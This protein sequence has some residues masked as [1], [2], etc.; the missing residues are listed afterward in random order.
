[1]K[2]IRYF[3]VV[4]GILLGSLAGG[5]RVF[6]DFSD[7]DTVMTISPPKQKMILVPG[8]VYENTI[9]V[10][11]PSDSESDLSYYVSVGSFNL[12]KDENGNN[13]DYESSDVDTITSRNQIMDWITLGKKEGTVAPGE[14]D[15]I[16][17]TIRVPENA[18]AGGQYA[19]I[20]VQNGT[21]GEE[22]GGG[23]VN[24]VNEVRFATTIIAE[25]A[26][27]TVDKG[28]ILENNIPSFLLSNNLEATSL[29]KNE[30][31]VHTDAEYILQVWPLLSDEEICTNEEEPETSLIMPDTERYHALS[32]KDMKG[33][34][35]PTLGIF[36]AKQSVKIFNETS[37]VERTIIICPLWLL[38]LILFIII[39][40]IIWVMTRVKGGKKSSKRTDD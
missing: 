32:T 35:L 5:F 12:G 11:N 33:C 15:P 29:V 36:R 17:Y 37:V 25:V 16:P 6:A 39:A 24:I 8:E 9:S 10:S 18:P 1:M 19:S 23:N 13:T 38:F 2:R 31:N 4:V 3:V 40:L 14:K 7:M 34:A 27:E 30:G 26:G 22:G 28:Q 21:K 20:I